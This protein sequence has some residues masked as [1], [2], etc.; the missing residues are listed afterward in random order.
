MELPE[1]H[2]CYIYSLLNRFKGTKK[3]LAL[4]MINHGLR[5]ITIICDQ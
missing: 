3:H 4:I 5:M 2:N 1:E